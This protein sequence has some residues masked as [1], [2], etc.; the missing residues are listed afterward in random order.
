[1]GGGYLLIILVLLVVTNGIT[2]G[3]SQLTSDGVSYQK[4]GETITVTKALDD[5][6]NTSLTK[7]DELEA[8]AKIYRYAELVDVVE[9]GDY[10]NYDAGKWSTSKTK[11]ES[12]G[13]FG[14]YNANTSKNASV[15]CY[16]ETAPKYQGWR[17]L[18]KDTNSRTVTIIHAG[19][20]ECYYHAS[21]YS[22]ASV[23]LLNKEAEQYM[24][25]Y[26]KSARS[27]IGDDINSLGGN[28]LRNI[29]SEYWLASKNG[30][31]HLY[32]VRA[33]GGE[34]WSHTAAMGFR[35]VIV[36]KSETLTN[37]KIKDQ[38]NNDAWKLI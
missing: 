29:G 23:E 18:S 34:A 28:D 24:N 1:M 27:S 10:V 38:F 25:T 2:Y 6:I 21:G 11:P 7:I 37:G 13:Q 14:G 30:Q 9:I 20:P 32:M 16:E 33:S 17:V 4:N 22:D 12:Q 26:A 15:A 8:K 35:P 36:L 5:L 3:A 19:Q 31:Y